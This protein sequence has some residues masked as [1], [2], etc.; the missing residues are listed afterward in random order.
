MPPETYVYVLVRADL[1]HPHL[2]IQAAHA[3]LAATISYGQPTARHPNLVILTVPDERALDAEFERLKEAG[4][5]AVCWDE[6]DMGGQ[7][8]AVAT[9]LLQGLERRHFRR[10]KL[11]S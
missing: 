9:G 4:I 5:P 1:P 10:F 2:T 11:L 6:D 7:R 3:V 8:T